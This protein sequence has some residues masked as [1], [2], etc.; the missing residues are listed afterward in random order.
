MP[1]ESQA[2]FF[3]RITTALSQRGPTMDLPEDLEAA[4]VMGDGPDLLDT[5]I[6][7]VQQSGMHP[8][9]VKGEPALVEMVSEI[10][11]SLSARSA[12][13]PEEPIPCRE[14]IVAALRER[15]INLLS[16]DER[17]AAFT[18]DLGITGIR[19]AVAETASM[20]VV[21]GDAHRRLASLAVPAH[22][23]V[24][25]ADQIVADL[26]DWGR[27]ASSEPPANEVLI[28]AMSKTADIEGILVPGV[29]GPGIV[30]VVLLE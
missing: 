7:R 26:L 13:V 9:R 20:S 22:I 28:S 21:S 24:V 3:A 30:H 8:H 15:G 4:R 10:A 12:I 2:T 27:T 17:D 23:A 25:R 29:H 5:F 18:A 11:S 6:Q 1:S 19:L 14:L 16:P